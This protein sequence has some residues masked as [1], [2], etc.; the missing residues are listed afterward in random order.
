MEKQDHYSLEDFEFLLSQLKE[1]FHEKGEQEYT[2][3]EEFRDALINELCKSLGFSKVISLRKISSPNNYILWLVLQVHEKFVYAVIFNV[4]WFEDRKGINMH[5]KM[6]EVNLSWVQNYTTKPLIEFEEV[7]KS[8]EKCDYHLPKGSDNG[9]ELPQFEKAIS[10]VSETYREK[11]K[12]KKKPKKKRKRRREG[13]DR[14]VQEKYRV[15]YPKHRE[16]REDYRREHYNPREYRRYHRDRQHEEYRFGSETC[17]RCHK[18]RSP[19]PMQGEHVH[20][21]YRDHRDLRDHRDPQDHRERRKHREHKEHREYKEPH[22]HRSHHRSRRKNA[23]DQI[24]VSSED[25]SED[26]Y[27]NQKKEHAEDQKWNKLLLAKKSKHLQ[28]I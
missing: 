4:I 13:R 23:S 22:D 2:S 12:T 11:H 9:Q 17:S 19:Y 25:A 20:Q 14:Q 21:R 28:N 7:L 10:K 8:D 27:K 24:Y 5:K 1:N 26:M 3:L 15:H 6:E 16:Y 18:P